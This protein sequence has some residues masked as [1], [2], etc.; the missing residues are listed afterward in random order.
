MQKKLKFISDSFHYPNI[1]TIFDDYPDEEIDYQK[2]KTGILEVITE[3]RDKVK[4][5][6]DDIKTIFH[7]IKQPD[8]DYVRLENIQK[9][10]NLE[11]LNQPMKEFYFARIN[12][13]M[14]KNTLFK[15][16]KVKNSSIQIYQ[17]KNAS[18]L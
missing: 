1:F 18:V 14:V 2:F 4:M 8:V 17:L 15:L 13:N 9:L 16:G 5:S 10:K 11:D 3:I 6:E 12:R 7:L